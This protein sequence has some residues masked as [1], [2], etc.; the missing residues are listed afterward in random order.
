MSKHPRPWLDYLDKVVNEAST[1]EGRA[2][3]A[4]LIL[5]I[6]FS[7]SLIILESVDGI[8]LAY[9]G[10]IQGLQLVFLGLFTLEYILRILV[11]DR[12]RDYLFSFFGI[13]DLMAI[14]PTYIGF[15][16]PYGRIFPVIRTLRLLRLF[17][18]F[19]M[20]RYV[21]ESGTLMKALRASRQ[22]ITVFVAAILFIITVVG[23]LM[24]VVEGP[25][26]GFVSIPEAMYW[27][28]VTVSTVGYGDISPQTQLGKI[29]A[30]F[31]MIVGYGIIAVPTGIITTEV[32]RASQKKKMSESRSC[33]P[34]C[35][36]AEHPA[37]A[38]YCHQCGDRLD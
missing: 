22:R 25:A 23:A 2:F 34:R 26:N 11:V 27:A 19:K 37:E 31:L 9:G 7:S 18:V 5:S 15:F 30:S 16:M 24:Y 4:V 21:E 12:K 3:D 10:I 38:R 17:S 35:G 36:H 6:I 20:G 28:V 13:I 29:I 8:R 1:P 33:C 14:L 32:H